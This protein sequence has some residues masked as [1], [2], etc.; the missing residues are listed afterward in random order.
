MTESSKRGR[1]KK[2]EYL[3]V[4]DGTHRKDRHGEA[5]DLEDLELNDGTLEPPKKFRR[6]RQRQIWDEFVKPCPWLSHYDR[7]K[8]YM[9]VILWEAFE[10]DPLIM[11]GSQLTQLRT[12]Q[13]ELGL[14]DPSNGS[15]FAGIGGRGAAAKDKDKGKKAKYLSD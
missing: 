1:K 7:P 6:K 8:A 10:K 4:V 12:I 11:N 13:N 14:G 9:F 3:H 5:P 15:R 2:P